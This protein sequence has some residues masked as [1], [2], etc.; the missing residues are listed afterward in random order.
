MQEMLRL[1]QGACTEDTQHLPSRRDTQEKAALL[2]VALKQKDVAAS[3]SEACQ[4]NAEIPKVKTTILNRYRV[5]GVVP[6]HCARKKNTQPVL[7]V[8]V[9][10]HAGS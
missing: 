6:G 2:S 3:P 4:G 1:L 7:L 5:E 10:N 8:A 9:Q